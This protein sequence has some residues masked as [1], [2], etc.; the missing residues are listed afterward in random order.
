[1]NSNPRPEVR[2]NAVANHLVKSGMQ[3]L[4]KDHEN[5]VNRHWKSYK[6]STNTE[7]QIASSDACDPIS[8]EELEAAL[9]LLKPGKASGYDQIFPEFLLNLG[10]S[11]K[12]WLTKFMK[13]ILH[14][15]HLPKTWRKAK[16]ISI[17]KPGK[18]NKLPKNYRPISL[19]SVSYKLFERIILQ[20]IL[21]KIESHLTID[22]AGFRSGRSAG[23]QVLALTTFIENGFQTKL[24]T[25]AIFL[26]LSAAY[27][28]VWHKGLLLKLSQLL[29]PWAVNIIECLLRNR[30]FRVHMRD[31][32]SRWRN[33]KNGLPQGSV[34]APILFNIYTNDIPPTTSRRFIY[35][36]D[37]CCAYQ[38]RTFEELET[39]LNEDLA[40]VANFFS[41]WRLKPNTT[42]TVSSVFHLTNSCCNRQLNV[43]L[44]G[45]PISHE[46]N[47]TYLGITLD[48]ALTYNQHLRKLSA[49]IRTR[50][51]LLQMLAGST[52]GANATVLRTTGLALC[53][54]TAE[55][56][57]P[58]WKN[59]AHCR[60]IDAQLNSTMRIVSGAI[61][62][63]A[64]E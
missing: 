27:D 5:E 57:C 43:H 1:M 24:K 46:P 10:H 59:S 37:I 47:P 23:E 21:P 28:S 2:A 7:Q 12:S 30:R 11:A 31:D 55:Y 53:F 35:A 13:R 20:R 33:Q 32:T 9:K 61:K 64:T 41:K 45:N 63:T 60:R 6:E 40:K 52:W 34:L 58:S 16:I 42:K 14:E 25:G 51:N 38:A 49:K 3:K 15:K 18:D 26:D 48:R 29:P 56:C 39:I 22:Q 36:D 50:N 62:A 17:P 8:L 19:L 4:P 54:S 44:R